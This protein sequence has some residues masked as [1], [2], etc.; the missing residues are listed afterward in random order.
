MHPYAICTCTFVWPVRAPVHD[1]SYIN[2]CSYQSKESIAGTFTALSSMVVTKV[3]KLSYWCCCEYYSCECCGVLFSRYE[4]VTKMVFS[5]YDRRMILYYR[6]L[7]RATWK[8]LMLFDQ[9]RIQ[10]HEGRHSEDSPPRKKCSKTIFHQY[11]APSEA[12]FK[13]IVFP[14]MH[15]QLVLR[16]H[17]AVLPVCIFTTPVAVLY[18]Y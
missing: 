16:L 2:S 8:L 13:V 18:L 17:Q 15:N 9:G 14:E 6:C 10:S 1:P 4:L 11:A 3:R 12:R 5:D 7:G